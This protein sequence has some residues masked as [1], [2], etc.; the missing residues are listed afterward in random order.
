[1]LRETGKRI[2]PHAASGIN[3]VDDVGLQGVVQEDA[4]SH[5]LKEGQFFQGNGLNIDGLIHAS[6]V[7]PVEDFELFQRLG[8]G[9]DFFHQE[10]VHLCFG[11]HVSTFF[12]DGVLGCHDHEGLGQRVD[13]STDGGLTFLHGFKHRGLGLCRG[14]VN[15]IQEHDIGVDGAQLGRHF[16]LCLVPDTRT[17]DVVRHE[18]RRALDAMEA[19]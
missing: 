5:L 3:Q 7:D 17:D 1:M 14:T 16:V 13:G 11:E 2:R 19:S 4:T 10:A 12:F 6:R 15:F 18:V 9:D 8:V